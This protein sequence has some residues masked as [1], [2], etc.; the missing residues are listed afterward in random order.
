MKRNVTVKLILFY[1]R[2][3]RDCALCDL[4]AEL[5]FFFSGDYPVKLC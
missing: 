2:E 3:R 5:G 4:C 1:H